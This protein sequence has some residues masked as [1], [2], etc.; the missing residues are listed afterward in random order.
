MKAY[1][2]PSPPPPPP[3]TNPPRPS[4]VAGNAS[5]YTGL[6][7]PEEEGGEVDDYNRVL[8]RYISKQGVQ[9]DRNSNLNPTP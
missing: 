9:G 8:V 7:N 6:L 3:L 1:P 2:T 4:D 5:A